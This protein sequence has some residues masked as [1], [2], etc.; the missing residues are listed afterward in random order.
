MLIIIFPQRVIG[1]L[2]CDVEEVVENIKIN[3]THK[4]Y[5]ILILSHFSKLL[6]ICGWMYSVDLKILTSE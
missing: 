6:I 2:I 1:C 4:Q 5:L 3:Q